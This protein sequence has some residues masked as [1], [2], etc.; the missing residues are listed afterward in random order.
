[1]QVLANPVAWNKAR[2]GPGAGQYEARV[3]LAV[4]A[5]GTGAVFIDGRR[6]WVI[7]AGS[8]GVRKKDVVDA[9]ELEQ[10]ARLTR[11]FDAD[12]TDALK[13]T[14]QGR[15][16][17]AAD[18]KVGV[19]ADTDT[20]TL[21]ITGAP[22]PRH[23]LGETTFTGPTGA[24]DA[25]D[26]DRT[27]TQK[28]L[29]GAFLEAGD[30]FERGKVTP[31]AI[32]KALDAMRE[33]YR[34]EGYLGATFRRLSLTPR[35]QGASMRD[36]VVIFVDPG[37]RAW[38]A[39]FNVAGGVPEIDPKLYALAVALCVAP[40]MA[41]RPV[42]TGRRPAGHARRLQPAVEVMVEGSAMLNAPESAA[43]GQNLAAADMAAAK[44]AAS[45]GARPAIARELEARFPQ[46]QIRQ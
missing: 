16:H 18:V 12:G 4:G 29:R 42:Q 41:G 20:V 27:W 2:G 40:G 28:Y 45:H 39:G 34:A 43:H 15:G 26:G 32:D 21:T 14:L 31:Q 23:R 37:P 13:A 19:T 8:T 22:G 3:S 38:L 46:Q 24:L 7:D 5:D 9:L 36:D 25:P 1:M 17:L 11:T 35:R 33:F 10:G 6:T 30:G 44:I